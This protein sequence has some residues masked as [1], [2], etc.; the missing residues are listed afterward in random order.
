MSIH[1]N[2]EVQISR[3]EFIHQLPDALENRPYEIDGNHIR[4]RDGDKSIHIRLIDEGPDQQGSLLLPMK[5][6]QFEFDGHTQAEA[7]AFMDH[8]DQHT[9]RFGGM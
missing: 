2:R 9:L 8:Y 4:V 7:E 3:K 6:V 1:I 5:E